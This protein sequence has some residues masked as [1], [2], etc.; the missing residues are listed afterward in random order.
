MIKKIVHEVL[1]TKTKN[2]NKERNK[3]LSRTKIIG[4]QLKS[5]REPEQ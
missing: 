2:R 1:E 4:R 5:D 3:K